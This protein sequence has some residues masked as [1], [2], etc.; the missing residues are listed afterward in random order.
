M[1][2]VITLNSELETLLY[3]RAAQKGQDVNFL[4][5]E[6]LASVLMWQ[7]QDLEETIKGI[8]QGL[9]DFEVGQYRS[10]EDFAEEKR[11]HYNLPDV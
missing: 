4:A 2:I 7:E 5:S 8:Q 6:L 1:A 11:K 3:D 10:F 9:N